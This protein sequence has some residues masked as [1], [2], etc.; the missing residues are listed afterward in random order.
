LF[1][2]LTGQTPYQQIKELFATKGLP[3]K[4]TQ[5]KPELLSVVDEVIGRMCAFIPKERY[6]SLAEVIEDLAIIG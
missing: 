2:L 1:E 4:P 6:P 3:Q 5:V